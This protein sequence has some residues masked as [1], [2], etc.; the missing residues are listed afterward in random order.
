LW[1]CTLVTENDVAG[2]YLVCK[3]LDLIDRTLKDLAIDCPSYGLLL[4]FEDFP[5]EARG[6][7]LQALQKNGTYELAFPERFANA[8]ALYPRSPGLWLLEPW[9]QRGINVD[10][11]AAQQYLAPIITACA[12]GRDRVPTRVKFSMSVAT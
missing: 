10:K 2:L 12:N 5:N 7:V 8:L 6:P 11:E 1:P 9:F 4:Q 3:T